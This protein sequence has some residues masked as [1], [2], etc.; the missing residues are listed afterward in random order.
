MV[1][2]FNDG[3]LR[4]GQIVHYQTVKKMIEVVAKYN[5][6]NI[7]VEFIDNKADLRKYRGEQDHQ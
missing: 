7:I 2:L 5:I 3:D 1:R 4:Y 6:Y